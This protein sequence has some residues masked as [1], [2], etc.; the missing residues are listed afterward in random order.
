MN[1]TG[2]ESLAV[3]G[4]PL[5]TRTE[6]L[7]LE[8]HA[9]TLRSTH[10]RALF[11]D[12]PDRFSRF[13]FKLGPLLVDYS[14]N[15]ITTE[16][17]GLLLELAQARAVDEGRKSMFAGK[18][19][20]ST[21]K[22]TALHIAL[23]KG[24]ESE[25]RVGET[26]VMPDVR[27]TLARIKSFTDDV[28]SGQIKGCAGKA[29]RHVVNIGIGGSHV[30]PM[31]VAQALNDGQSAPLS[32]DFVSN[33]DGVQ[34]NDTLGGLDPAETLFVICSKTFTT[35]ETMSNA[36]AAKDWLVASLGEQ[37]VAKHMAAV[38][39]ASEKVSAFGISPALTFPIWDWVG[40]RFSLWSAMSLAAILAN[41]Y[42]P[43]S[44][45]LA[46]AEAMDEHFKTAPLDQNL[47]VILAMIGVW[48][49]DFLGA[50]A[51]AI[52]PY[53]HSLRL[54]PA[55]L[56]QLDMESNGKGVMRD[57]TPVGT[58]AAPIVFGGSGSDS[59]HSFFQLIH[60]SPRL[61]PCDFIAALS[62]ATEL[63]A[64]RDLLLSNVF[65]QSESLMRGRTTN[66]MT[67][68]P[69]DMVAHKTFPGNKPSNT[70]LLDEVSPYSIGMLA[71]LYE[72]KAFVQSLVWGVNAFDQWG[73]E[74]SKD[75]AKELEPALS[76]DQGALNVLEDAGSGS[77]VGLVTAYLKAKSNAS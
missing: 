61:V 22:R 23:R 51:F 26:D 65:G 75:V 54:F 4:H 31:F 77:T 42:E 39:A 46:G 19:I 49:T 24:G 63:S 40:G 73:V 41:G 1:D 57:G 70:L 20:N 66:E 71:A 12:D 25:V 58:Q 30:G 11:K 34:L 59:Q 53:E 60:Q 29:F 32:V 18:I 8:T 68:T 50:T 33:L 17:M 3:T 35:I 21:E 52:L 67:N 43:F 5:T 38:S 10:M 28:R 9:E 55:H 76:G 13:S 64:N 62:G 45:M 16:T 72:H 37:A 6:W 74:L 7:A 14:K 48:N 36:R 2:A 44:Q 56:Q 47:P 15:R 27:A 69:A